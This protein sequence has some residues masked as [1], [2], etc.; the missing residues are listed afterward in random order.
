MLTNTFYPDEQV[1]KARNTQ[2]Q[3]VNSHLENQCFIINNRE[4]LA[5]YYA[6]NFQSDGET[7]QTSRYVQRLLYEK[8]AFLACIIIVVPIC[9]LIGFN[10]QN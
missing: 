1:I 6:V 7:K 3:I 8:P 5:M 10:F 9:F 4:Y 2:Y